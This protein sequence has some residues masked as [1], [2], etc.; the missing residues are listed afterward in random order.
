MQVIVGLLERIGSAMPIIPSPDSHVLLTT[1]CEPNWPSRCAAKMLF[2]LAAHHLGP[3]FV[4]RSEFNPV[5]EF[6]AGRDVEPVEAVVGPNGEQ[7]WTMDVRFVRDWLQPD[8]RDGAWPLRTRGHGLLLDGHDGMLGGVVMLW[9]RP[10]FKVTLAQFDPSV[11][12]VDAFPVLLL[13]EGEQESVE[14]IHDMCHHFGFIDPAVR[15]G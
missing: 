6:I 3:E 4:L 12:V 7:G 8:P 9:G 15:L 14:G 5:R 10:T 2:N 13:K 1:S 11:T